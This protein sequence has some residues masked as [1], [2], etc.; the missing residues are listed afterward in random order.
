MIPGQGLLLA[1]HLGCPGE[2]RVRQAGAGHHSNA[3]AALRCRA[4][5]Q[6]T[7]RGPATSRKHAGRLLSCLAYVSVACVYSSGFAVHVLPWSCAP[8]PRAVASP[9]PSL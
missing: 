2:H 6:S 1:C 7:P 4:C 5:G 8:S 3:A 9:G